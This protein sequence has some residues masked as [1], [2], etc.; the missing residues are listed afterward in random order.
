VARGYLWLQAGAVASWWLCLWLWPATRAAFAVP[1]WPDATL[2]SFA[3]GDLLLLVP[4]SAAAAATGSTAA[5]L[6]ALGAAAYA[7]LWCLQTS[8]QHDGPWLATALMVAATAGTA[9]AARRLRGAA[10]GPP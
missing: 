6:L 8:L 2:L 9:A 3:L 7:T 1:G 10:E 5:A 4:A